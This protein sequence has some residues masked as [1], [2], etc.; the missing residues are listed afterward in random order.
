MGAIV[1]PV[2]RNQIAGQ[3]TISSICVVHVSPNEQI[4]EEVWMLS[5]AREHR[6]KVVEEASTF[7]LAIPQRFEAAVIAV[8]ALFKN[9]VALKFT[10]ISNVY[11]IDRLSAGRHQ[12]RDGLANHRMKQ[13][14]QST[15]RGARMFIGYLNDLIVRVRGI[16]LSHDFR[17][18]PLI[19]EMRKR[20]ARL[21]A[22]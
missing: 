13:C 5:L 12:L 2:L 6:R 3:H 7:A 9:T 18:G 8:P 21:Q 17:L 10:M 16:E 22:S 19:V 11:A 1:I 4:L 20:D 14:C 15:Y